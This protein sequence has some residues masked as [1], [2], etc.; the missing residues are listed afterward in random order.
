MGFADWTVLVK[1]FLFGEY[2]L[3]ELHGIMAFVSGFPF[4]FWFVIFGIRRIRKNP[5]ISM[6]YGNKAT[7]Q[8]AWL[9]DKPALHKQNE[10]IECL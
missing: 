3:F 6:N 2:F 4:E 9:E 8:F 7:A 1:L 5:A 10:L